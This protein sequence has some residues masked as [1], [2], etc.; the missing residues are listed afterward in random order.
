MDQIPNNK[1]LVLFDGV[2]NLCNTS[3]QFLIK[4]DHNQKLM[5]APLQGNT[6]KT[7]SNN[8]NINLQKTDSIILYN[9]ALDKIYIKS[10][11]AIKIAKCLGFPY[12]F[13]VILYLIPPFLRNIIYDFIAK[14]RYKW[15]GKKENC[16]I[17]TPQLKSRFLS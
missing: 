7:I 10:T 14:N 11:A 5:F 16:M 9:P 13:A 4:K 2:C 3:V 6:G 1:L 12:Y 15:Y 17:P 8:F